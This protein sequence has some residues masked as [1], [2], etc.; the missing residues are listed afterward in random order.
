M[1]DYSAPY[2]EI[3]SDAG[4]FDQRV[5]AAEV[6]AGRT[7]PADTATVVVDNR[8]LDFVGLFRPD[9]RI[10]INLGY[11]ETGVWSVFTG[12]IV[13]V[14]GDKNMTLSCKD[15]MRDCHRTFITKSFVDVR[16]IDVVAYC[17]TTAKISKTDI[18]GEDFPKLRHFV[19]RRQNVTQAIKLVERTWGITGWAHR[20][21]PEGVFEWKKWER[22]PEVLVFETGKNIFD[23]KPRNELWELETHLFPWV[24]HGQVARVRDERLGFEEEDLF[25]V[26]RVLYRYSAA[27]RMTL[28]L[29]R[30]STIQKHDEG[31]S[32]GAF[33]RGC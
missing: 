7:N 30:L 11:R 21:T 10:T 4:A 1:N 31:D 2:C 6:D 17:L 27:P 26:E 29:R 3:V 8:H 14:S 32:W 20:F 25:R 5:T 23:F 22:A 28:W 16:P 15:L 33:Q 19:L 9:T 13:D 24:V 12:Y 18:Q